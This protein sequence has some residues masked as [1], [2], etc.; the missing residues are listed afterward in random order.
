MD[1]EMEVTPDLGPEPWLPLAPKQGRERKTEAPMAYAAFQSFYL[2]PP[3]ERGLR[4]L[5]RKLGKHRTQMDVWSKRFFWPLRVKAWDRRQS[6]LAAAERERQMREQE[7]LRMKRREELHEEMFH[8]AEELR[9]RGRQ[10]LKHPIT[11]RT[12]Q[13]TDAS[14]NQVITVKPSKFTQDT[15]IHMIL[16]GVKLG[17]DSIKKAGGQSDTGAV[18]EDYEIVPFEP[19]EK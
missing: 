6:L 12:I 5:A 16:A 10:M 17:E 3:G 15:A 4:E 2:S 1:P 19:E 8:L 13:K 18:I 9:S 14:G 7:A 11:E